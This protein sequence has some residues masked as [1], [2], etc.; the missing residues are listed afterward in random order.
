[1]AVVI[2]SDFVLSEHPDIPLS[3]PRILYDDVWRDGDITPS[4]EEEGAEG[5]NVSD[6]LT[7]DYWRATEL[8]ANIE[9][10]LSASAVVDYV[11]IASHTLGTDECSVQAQ[12]HDGAGWVDMFDEYAPGTDKVVA[13]L[14]EEV[15]ASRFRLLVNSGNSPGT[16]PS[17]GII[18][19]GQALAV[20]R[21]VT[22]NHKPIT[23]QRRSEVRPNISEGGKTLGRSVQRQGVET[24][25]AFD[26]LDADWFRT[27]FDPFIESARVHPFGWVWHPVSYPAEVAFLWTPGDQP[28]IHPEQA[29]LP[30]TLS[31]S[32]DVEGI[33][34]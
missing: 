2:S 27:Y 15:T 6:G 5:E 34:E 18:M 26:H 17:I 28:D 8:P 20:E 29:G 13:F 30:N 21:G 9:V 33:V 32:F 16:P 1:M 23:M 31:V 3:H 11:L 19:M 12:Y 24:Q 7:W 14:F 25:I 4:T 22:L 10:Q